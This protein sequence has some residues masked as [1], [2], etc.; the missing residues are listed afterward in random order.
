LLFANIL[1]GES[2]PRGGALGF[3]NGLMVALV[4]A[5]VVALLMMALVVL[6]LLVFTALV[7]VCL[8]VLVILE[9]GVIMR[10]L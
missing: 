2:I 5:P 6:C 10:L 4:L 8:L 3:A 7:D 1:L 9:F